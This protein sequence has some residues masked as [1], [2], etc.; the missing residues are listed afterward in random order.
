ME[1]ISKHLTRHELWCV[2]VENKNDGRR[3]VVSYHK[4]KS[5]AECLALKIGGAAVK[6]FSWLDEY[7]EWWVVEAKNIGV[8]LPDRKD[9]IAKLSP[10]ERR[11]LGV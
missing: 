4:S 9:V 7:G 10:N 6:E 1:F 2:T 5:A 11:V 3:V 8:D